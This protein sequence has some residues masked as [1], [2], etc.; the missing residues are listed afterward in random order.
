[1]RMNYTVSI[2]NMPARHFTT[3]RAASECA[4]GLKHDG[5]D[6]VVIDN[7]DPAGGTNFAGRVNRRPARKPYCMRCMRWHDGNC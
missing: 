3:K 1:M 4:A 7:T 6:A 2:R 5:H